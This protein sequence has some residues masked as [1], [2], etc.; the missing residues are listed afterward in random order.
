[1]RQNAFLRNEVKLSSG[2]SRFRIRAFT[3]KT[4]R[5]RL[6]HRGSSEALSNSQHFEGG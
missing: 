4:R 3:A 6:I 1:M 5:T 2:G